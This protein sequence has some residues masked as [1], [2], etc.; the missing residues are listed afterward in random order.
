[1]LLHLA[2]LI[3]P[4]PF[5]GPRCTLPIG[6]QSTPPPAKSGPYVYINWGALT[7]IQG[8]VPAEAFEG[9]DEAQS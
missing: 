8:Q 5:L 3:E 7:Q 2:H 4:L 9:E 1:M 6:Y